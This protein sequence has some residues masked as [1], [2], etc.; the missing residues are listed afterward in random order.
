ML[1]RPQPHI[2]LFTKRSITFLPAAIL[3]VALSLPPR[4]PTVFAQLARWQYTTT[5]TLPVGKL[6]E[7]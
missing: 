1:L 3:R 7:R 2:T 5:Q 4:K 6:V